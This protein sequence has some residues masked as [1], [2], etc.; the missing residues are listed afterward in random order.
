MWKKQDYGRLKRHVLIFFIILL[1]GL[2]NM[3]AK[4]QQNVLLHWTGEIDSV[5]NNPGNWLPNRV[6][7]ETDDVYLSKSSSSAYV[8]QSASCN[9]LVIEKGVKL[10]LSFGAR[11]AVSGNL[12]NSGLFIAGNGTVSFTGKVSQEIFSTTP[13]TFYNLEVKNLSSQG[14]KVTCKANV[15]HELLL[16]KGILQANEPLIILNSNEDAVSQHSIES[17]VSGKLQRSIENPADGKYLFPV[18]LKEQGKYFQAEID[19]HA[20]SGT[21]WISVSFQPL[22]RYQKSELNIKDNEMNYDYLAQEGMW[23][24]TPD[25]EPSAGWFDVKLW[26]ENMTGLIDNQF[27][28][29]KRPVGS[30]TGAFAAD[31]GEMN[32]FAGEGR[33]LSHGYALRKYCTSFSEY[34]IGGGGEAIPIELLGFDAKLENRVVQLSW[35]TA[36]ETNNELFVVEKSNGTDFTEVTKINGSGNSS[37]RRH[38]SA[39][40]EK[41]FSGV[42]YYR[43]RQIDFNGDHQFSKIISV[44]NANTGNQMVIFPNPA[45]REVKIKFLNPVPKAEVVIF[46]Q[47]GTIS[48]NKTYLTSEDSH[49]IEL[50]LWNDLIPGIYYLQVSTGTG[51][52]AIQQII[53]E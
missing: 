29:L 27:G 52:L 44:N 6:P 13:L 45:S 18:G 50:N 16:N 21:N 1:L 46:N 4:A 51:D 20:L 24:I 9:D 17:Y 36:T 15:I 40:D 25:V 22:E 47:H 48:Y 39:A 34:A 38:Y 5:W 37:V 32:V 49:S 42:S 19:A 30:G 14:I 11:L 8:F 33:L 10:T 43:L 41:P 31:F 3:K 28:I 23:V 7:R 35:S 2:L 53:L 12:T 26:L